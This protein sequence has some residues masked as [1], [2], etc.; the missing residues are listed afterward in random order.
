MSFVTSLKADIEHFT[1]GPRAAF[2]FIHTRQRVI[3]KTHR[4]KTNKDIYIIRIGII[5]LQVFA[6]DT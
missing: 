1:K 2:V 6:D 3:H 4:G 5:T